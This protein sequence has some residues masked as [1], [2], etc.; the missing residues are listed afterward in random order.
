MGNGGCNCNVTNLSKVSDDN[1]RKFH[2]VSYEKTYT[3]NTSDNK[4][5]LKEN[6]FLSASSASSLNFIKNKN[7]SNNQEKE[8]LRDCLNIIDQNYLINFDEEFDENFSKHNRIGIYFLKNDFDNFLDKSLLAVSNTYNKE[9]LKLLQIR[10]FSLNKDCNI[11]LLE[12]LRDLKL[13]KVKNLFFFNFNN[14]LRILMY[15]IFL[16]EPPSNSDYFYKVDKKKQELD[17]IDLDIMRTFPNNKI[18]S[19]D[20]FTENL[21]KVL[22]A[23]CQSDQDLGYVQGMNFLTCYYLM[24][25]GNNYSFTYSL[26]RRVF[27]LE[28][29]IFNL[30]YRETLVSGFPLLYKYLTKFK[31]LIEVRNKDVDLILK[32]YE[33]SDFLWV[34]KW[35]QTLFTHKFS[36]EVV[37]KFHDIIV[38]N[39]LDYILLI[40]LAMVDYI[41]SKVIK[42][43][44]IEDFII[45]CEDL[46][47]IKGERFTSFYIFI[48]NKIK[49]AEFTKL[50]T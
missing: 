4:L 44:S 31:S 6:N 26:L 15:N 2:N 47:N 29:R 12:K 39:G 32:K 43:S 41:Q 24:L 23:I 27:N 9:I 49:S 28:S 38:I 34:S 18:F 36:F 8:M 33:V 19:Q 21:R 16:P 5:I 40:L 14:S 10:D 1:K 11:K 37:S 45:I 46:Y 17:Q 30:K 50:L 3:G 20:N 42:I 7:V 13:Q 35:I 22:R 25:A 48:L